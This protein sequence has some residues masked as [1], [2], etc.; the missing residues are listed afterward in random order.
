MRYVGAGH[1]P[2]SLEEGVAAP[3]VLGSRSPPRVIRASLAGQEIGSS[4]VSQ[5]PRPASWLPHARQAKLEHT[6]THTR[7]AIEPTPKPS[8]KVRR[9]ALGLPHLICESL[10]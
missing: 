9:Y 4:G 5:R 3:S 7:P 2:G 1:G 10:G 8:E 6:H